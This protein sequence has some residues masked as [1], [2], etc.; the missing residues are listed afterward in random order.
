MLFWI[1]T[2]SGDRK[3]SGFRKKK[4]IWGPLKDLEPSLEKKEP[5]AHSDSVR[6]NLW[7]VE[8]GDKTKKSDTRISKLINQ[9]SLRTPIWTVHFPWNVNFLKIFCVGTWW[10]CNSL[11]HWKQVFYYLTTLTH[12]SLW[13]CKCICISNITTPDS[14]SICRRSIAND[15]GYA[16]G[17][18]SSCT[19][20]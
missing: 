15:K 9:I 10:I 12:Q 20:K 2:S 3:F 8:A 5:Q 16:K 7:T 18:I 14:L 17:K 19:F 13:I 6:T 11:G 4:R 1:K